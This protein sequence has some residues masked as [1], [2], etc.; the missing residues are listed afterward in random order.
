MVLLPYRRRRVGDA[1]R[2]RA[3]SAGR[4]PDHLRPPAPPALLN[5]GADEP[6]PVPESLP[7]L[8]EVVGAKPPRHV[9]R[10][11]ARLMGAH[12]VHMMCTARGASNARAKE[13]LGWEPSFPTWREGFAQLSTV[14]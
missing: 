10:W 11:V 7:V 13:I 3:P 8:A 5:S 1:C 14:S 9:P 4:D 12:L 6:A 2:A